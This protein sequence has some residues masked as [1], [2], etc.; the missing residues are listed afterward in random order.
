MEFVISRMRDFPNSDPN[1][2]GL[3]GFD[4]G[5]MSALILQMRNTDVDAVVSLDSGIGFEHNTRLLKQSPYYDP[6][7]V[8]VPL[9]HATGTKAGIEAAGARED[10]GLFDSAM[11]SNTYRL[12]IKGMRHVDF[13]SYSMIEGLLPGSLGPGRGKPKASYEVLCSYI[14]S[15][16][17]AFVKGDQTSLALLKHEPRS[18]AS[19]EG[20]LTV[21]VKDARPAPPTEEQFV[22]TIL[23]EGIEKAAQM[24]REARKTHPGYALFK[25]A[26][27][28]RLGCDYLYRKA[29]SKTAI[30]IFKLNVEAFPQSFNVYDSLAEACLVNRD[31]ERAITN[32]R[33]SLEL[34]PHN[35]NARAKLKELGR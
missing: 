29:D 4:L 20:L 1:K 9:M 7:R 14:L 11:Y 22:N 13:T 34:N 25:E 30:E 33:K 24:Y 3:I 2:L 28:N 26:T 6:T 27:L 32:Y 21:E 8:R 17:N 35:A 10:P 16:L 5:G 15:F 19:R 12:R 23:E 18:L 31:K